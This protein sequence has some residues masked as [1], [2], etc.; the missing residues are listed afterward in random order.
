MNLFLSTLGRR[1]PGNG[2]SRTTHKMEIGWTRLVVV[3]SVDDMRVA[4]NIERARR[5][6]SVMIRV[7]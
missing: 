3:V 6:T 7:S 1:C 2:S 4:E 5:P